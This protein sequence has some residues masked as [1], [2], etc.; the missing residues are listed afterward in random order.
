M[1]KYQ[2]EFTGK[3]SEYF[4]IWI[5][6][7]LLSIVTLGIYTAWAK[8]RRLRYFYGNTHLDG[9]NFEY[10]AKPKSIL[11]GR[12]IVVG[13]LIAINV[14]ATFIPIAVVIVLPIYL[15]G[16][17]WIINQAM[18]FNARVTSYRN[19]RFNFAGTYWG[20]MKNFIVLPSILFF[21][22]GMVGFG[23]VFFFKG[24]PAIQGLVMSLTFIGL[25]LV[26][27]YLSKLISDYI[28]QNLSYGTAEFYT[29]INIRGL[30]N[31]LGVTAI[32]ATVTIIVLGLV[33]ALFG[34][35]ID[36]SVLVEKMKLG[37]GT[38]QF[39]PHVMASIFAA[40][41]AGYIAIIISALFYR[42]GCAQF[43]V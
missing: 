10:H 24:L 31:N 43:G 8:V 35:L 12:L 7:L 37:A 32:F 36:I 27:P 28:G 39:D 41:I 5:V 20:A 30:F 25:L 1:T 21:G 42:A 19:V 6:N 14:I 18:R 34:N 40:T 11:I 23:L 17:P 4:G 26:F 16:L 29:N 9:H 22:V 2:F 3:A 33:G 13:I 38:P 15:F